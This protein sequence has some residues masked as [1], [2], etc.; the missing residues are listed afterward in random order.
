MKAT[1]RV[2]THDEMA[3]C[4]TQLETDLSQ[5]VSCTK[6]PTPK[7]AGANQDKLPPADT[8]RSHCYQTL[9]D[10]IS[11]IACSRCLSLSTNLTQCA[12]Y[13]LMW[14]RT[15]PSTLSGTRKLG[16]GGVIST[17]ML[18]LR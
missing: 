14:P 11:I 15:V 9:N 18:R 10:Q 16:V 17:L 3:R 6:N 13:Y 8:I 12:G 1:T 5:P 4:Q 7:A 2:H